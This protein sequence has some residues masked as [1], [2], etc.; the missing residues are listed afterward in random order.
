[1]RI[2]R[3]KP[4][5]VWLEKDLILPYVPNVEVCDTKC[6]SESE[7]KSDTLLFFHG[8]LKRNAVRNFFKIMCCLGCKHSDIIIILYFW[9][10]FLWLHRICLSSIPAMSIIWRWQ[11]S[12]L[13]ASLMIV[14]HEVSK[15]FMR[16]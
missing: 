2:H 4:G 5:E 9:M 10:K 3:Y 7:S 8:R 13:I 1:M 6:L 16:W 11:W 12:H 15:Q 14:L